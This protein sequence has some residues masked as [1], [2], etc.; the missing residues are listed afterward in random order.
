MDTIMQPSN[1]KVY[2]FLHFTF[3]QSKNSISTSCVSYLL[4][5]RHSLRFIGGSS[6]DEPLAVEPLTSLPTSRRKPQLFGIHLPPLF[7]LRLGVYFGCHWEH[8]RIEANSSA[9]RACQ[10]STGDKLASILSTILASLLSG[11][12][13]VP[14]RCIMFTSL[15]LSSFERNFYSQRTRSFQLLNILKLVFTIFK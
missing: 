3:L 14:A 9:Q 5:V 8:R 11:R 4:I 1:Q 7:G 10:P 2:Y 12:S 15:S 6:P 13:D